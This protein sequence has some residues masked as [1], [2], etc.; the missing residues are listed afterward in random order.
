MTKIPLSLFFSHTVYTVVMSA[1]QPDIMESWI[2]H[3]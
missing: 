3:P 2:R 1:S